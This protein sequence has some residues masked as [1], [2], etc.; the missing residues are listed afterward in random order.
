MNKINVQEKLKLFD[1]HWSP[2][3]VSELNGQYVKLVKVKGEFV[4]HDHKNEDELFFVVK[5]KLIIKLRD[6]DV[7]LNEG[8]FFVVPKGTEHKPVAEE[9]VHLLL[10]EPKETAH[11]GEVKHELTKEKLDW[12]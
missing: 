12:I 10:L 6:K 11:T 1:E 8:E 3:I 9:E 2:K 7:E 5:G 4:W